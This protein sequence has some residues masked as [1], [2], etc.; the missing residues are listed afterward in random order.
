MYKNLKRLYPVFVILLVGGSIVSGWSQGKPENSGYATKEMALSFGW[1]DVF[2]PLEMWAAPYYFRGE[3]TIKKEQLP[4]LL[5]SPIQFYANGKLFWIRGLDIRAIVSSE[6]QSV[7]TSDTTGRFPIRIP[8]PMGSN[9]VA[10]DSFADQRAHMFT[11]E[12]QGYLLEHMVEG[13][14]FT[15]SNYSERSSG[16][17]INSLTVKIENPWEEFSARF[18]IPYIKGGSDDISSWQIVNIKG[19][20]QFLRYDP[21]DSTNMKVR[22]IYSDPS[23]YGQR[24]IP[25]F[26]SLNRYISDNDLI[27][28][29]SQVSRCDTLVQ[30]MLDPYD[31]QDLIVDQNMKWTLHWGTLEGTYTGKFVKPN[32]FYGHLDAPMTMQFDDTVLPIHQAKVSMVPVKGEIEQVIIDGRYPDQWISRMNQVPSKTSIYFDEIIV[33]DQDGLIKLLPLQFLINLL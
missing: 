5:Q 22:G 26:R 9:H 16:V 31:R 21:S 1:G 15:F 25:A 19:N 14:Y 7:Q 12:T 17:V 10:V 23:K 20:K 18:S 27:V 28:P 6:N 24:R 8:N 29:P 13:D 32:E 30:K 2:E 4:E 33:E 3:I 11:L